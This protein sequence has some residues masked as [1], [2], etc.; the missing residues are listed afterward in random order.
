MRRRTY[1]AMAAICVAFWGS[2]A[3]AAKYVLSVAP[4]LPGGASMVYSTDV[5]NNGWA[6]GLAVGAGGEQSVAVWRDGGVFSVAALPS[7]WS[8]FSVNGIGDGGH[9][10]GSVR[11]VATGRPSPFVWNEAG[12][13]TIL[14]LEG[15][16]WDANTS[17]TTAVQG[18][19]N[20]AYVWKAGVGA[21]LLPDLPGGLTSSVAYGINDAGVV[22]GTGAVAG[23]SI[24]AASW[25]SSGVVTDLGFLPGGSTFSTALDINSSG[26][27]VGQSRSTSGA[28]AYLLSGGVMI[29]LGDLPGG[30]FASQAVAINDQGVVIGN[31]TA[32]GNANRP[33]VWKDGVMTD[34]TTLIEVPAG[35]SLESAR[36]INN[37]G[38]IVGTGLD[39]DGVRRAV[40]LT[41]VSA[42]GG[43]P[44]DPLIPQVQQN[45]AYQ[46]AF[47]AQ[48][49]TM[50]FL[51]PPTVEGY[52][53]KLISGPDILSALFPA[54]GDPNGY[55]VYSLSGALLGSVLG[56][57][58]FSFAGSGVRGFVLRGID[59]EF[60]PHDWVTGLTF[61][62]DGGVVLLQ[63]PIPEPSTW[64][65]MIV[66]AGLAGG[67]LRRVAARRL[68]PVGRESLA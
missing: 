30:S 12:G 40:L 53:Y 64:A 42:G 22:V 57:E 47:V 58:T 56:G 28:E 24:R 59:V 67:A 26:Q 25:N 5:N 13:L 4:S 44:A 46:F 10:V 51:D 33:F 3:A 1:A 15:I 48:A 2:E 6:A 9:V 35:W 39:T 17:G 32:T 29:G 23:T 34:L 66:G 18:W 62:G 65:M 63:S 50:V 43:T 49:G 41:P 55:E 16:G 7:G 21:T 45:G 20:R 8:N 27:I 38:Q 68:A 60:A 31:G 37:L 52:T 11:N 54:L 36:G 14:P 19:D 61:A